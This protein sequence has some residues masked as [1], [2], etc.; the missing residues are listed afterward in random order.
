MKM[1]LFFT[2]ILLHLCCFVFVINAAVPFSPKISNTN[3]GMPRGPTTTFGSMSRDPVKF[4]KD[5]VPQFNKP[6]TSIAESKALLHANSTPL[7]LNDPRKNINFPK[8]TNSLKTSPT[9]LNSNTKLESSIKSTKKSTN[10]ESSNQHRPHDHSPH[11]HPPHEHTPHKHFQH[12]HSSHKHS[13]HKHSSHK[14]APHAHSSDEHPSEYN[15]NISNVN[16]DDTSSKKDFPRIILSGNAAHLVY[17]EYE[18]NE[19]IRKT[20]NNKNSPKKEFINGETIK[21][22]VFSIFGVSIFIVCISFI[23]SCCK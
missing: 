11:G 22:M 2:S 3:V 19:V 4:N 14:H 20:M 6:F 9:D 21:I 10:N 8:I 23:S 12:E 5:H 13:S 1:K 18:F 7:G 17:N 15:D 16:H